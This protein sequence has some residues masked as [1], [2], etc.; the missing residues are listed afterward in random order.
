MKYWLGKTPHHLLPPHQLQEDED[1]ADATGLQRAISSVMAVDVISDHLR[2]RRFRRHERF[3]WML[4]NRWRRLCLRVAAALKRALSWCPLSCVARRTGERT[5][6][7]V[8]YPG[9]SS[10]SLQ[11]TYEC[12]QAADQSQDD[13]NHC[14]LRGLNW[15]C[16]LIENVCESQVAL[17][18]CHIA[19]RMNVQQQ[20]CVV[21]PW[22][23][24]DAEPFSYII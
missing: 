12:K 22:R 20:L 15:N 1:T 10:R 6:G 11:S 18:D 8:T 16:T 24:T 14:Y 2:R 13:P 23:R 5:P 21:A 9:L 19:G 3:G 7:A 17:T 4:Q